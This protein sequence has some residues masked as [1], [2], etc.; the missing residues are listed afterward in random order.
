MVQND[1]KTIIFVIKYTIPKETIAIVGNKKDTIMQKRFCFKY[2]GTLFL[3]CFF[4]DTVILSLLS[5]Y[6]YITA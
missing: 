1:N 5:L 4:K 3:E 6:A 2:Q